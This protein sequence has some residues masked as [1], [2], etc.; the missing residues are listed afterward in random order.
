VE[1]ELGIFCCEKENIHHLFFFNCCVA[2]DVCNMVSQ[3]VGLDV[4]A[5]FEST[6]QLW[7]SQ[8]RYGSVNVCMYFCHSMVLREN[9]EWF[10]FSGF[11]MEGREDG[12]KP[13]TQDIEKMDNSVQE[14]RASRP[15]PVGWSGGIEGLG[16]CSI[17][18]E[19][20]RC[21]TKFKLPGGHGS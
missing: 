10:G 11:G 20:R 18:L 15:G 7:L 1:D 21:R 6:V 3:I 17:G 19:G 13:S 14:P 16:V 4:G 8:K 2:V 12:T 9:S 5:D